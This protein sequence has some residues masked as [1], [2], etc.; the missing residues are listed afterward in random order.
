MEKHKVGAEKNKLKATPLGKSVTEFLSREYNDLFNY[1]FTATM[2]H[3]LDEIAHGRHEWKTLLQTTWDTYK[4]RYTEQTTGGASKSKAAR[5][6]ELAPGIKVILS[7]KGPLFVK[8]PPTKK[9]KAI[10]A[11]LPS[12][13]TFETATAEDAATAFGLVAAERAGE[14]VGTI[15]TDEIRKKKGPYGFYVQC[16]D[17]RVPWKDG[18]TL[19]TIQQKLNTKLTG[20]DASGAT[21]VPFERKVGDFT[22]KRGPYGLYFFKHTLKRTTFIKFMAPDPNTTTVAEL[23]ELYS[24]GIVRKRKIKPGEK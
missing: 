1:E 8:D 22:I 5:E 13:V 14:L 17:A 21:I 20:T 12:S 18:D 15:G 10:F 11:P 9:D 6:K 19:E 2:E 16:K 24:K 4:D 7:R 3:S 23:N